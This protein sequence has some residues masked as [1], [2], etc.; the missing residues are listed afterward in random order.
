V[1]ANDIHD[2]ALQLFGEGGALLCG[3]ETQLGVDRE[4]GEA[5]GGFFGKLDRTA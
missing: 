2:G 4:R 5:F 3:R 1:P